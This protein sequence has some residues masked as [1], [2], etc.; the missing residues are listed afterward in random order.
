MSSDQFFSS[1]NEAILERVLYQDIRRRIGG[2]LSEKQANRLIKT[3]K[4][5]MG[6]VH[7]VQS[8]ARSIADMNKEVVQVVLPDYLQYLQRQDRSNRS[9]ISDIEA[10]PGN[11]P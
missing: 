6:E 4:H 7:R 2:D 8:G 1:R 10:G 3:V 11:Q 9:V 5:Y